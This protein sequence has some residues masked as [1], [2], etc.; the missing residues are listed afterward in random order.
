MTQLP[1]K[2][3]F[4]TKRGRMATEVIEKRRIGMTRATKDAN[5][6]ERTLEPLRAD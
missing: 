2:P 3:S 6:W 5:D 1:L 4:M